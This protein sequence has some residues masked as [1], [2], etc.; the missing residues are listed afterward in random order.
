MFYFNYDVKK[1]NTTTT[2]IAL[3]LFGLLNV[4]LIFINALDVFNLLGSHELPKGIYL[5]DFLHN[6]VLSLVFSIIIAVGKCFL[7]YLMKIVTKK[8][9]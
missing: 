3:A 6:A 7:R 5:S 8:R 9:F 2:V 1:L 4:M